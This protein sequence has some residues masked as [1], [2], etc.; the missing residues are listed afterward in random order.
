MLVT[1]SVIPAQIA[2][3]ANDNK[4]VP[5]NGMGTVVQN[6]APDTVAIIDL[7]RFPPKILVEIE[8]TASVVGPS[9]SMTIAPD[10]SLAL[11]PAAMKIAP[12]DATN[13]AL[14]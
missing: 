12:N 5:V 13:G 2:V 4:V 14:I 7:K 1:T 8:V 6:S 10:E 11:V 3:A 9:F